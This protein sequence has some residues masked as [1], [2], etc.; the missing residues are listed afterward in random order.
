MNFSHALLSMM[1][2]SA[3]PSSKVT[4][5]RC[6]RALV[7]EPCLR[8][9]L[10]R[11]ESGWTHYA[12]GCHADIVSLLAVIQFFRYIVQCQCRFASHS[13]RT[14]ASI[15]PKCTLACWEIEFGADSPDLALKATMLDEIHLQ[16]E[17]WWTRFMHHVYMRHILYAPLFSTKFLP[18]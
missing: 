3:M 7:R 4:F 18:R 17:G 14:L 12:N 13:T 9:L 16:S 8:V 10:H 15:D 1:L 6:T 5:E 11:Q 2:T